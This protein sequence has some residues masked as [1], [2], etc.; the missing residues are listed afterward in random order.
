MRRLVT[1]ASVLG[2]AACL[3]ARAVAQNVIQ[4]YHN[5]FR[6]SGNITTTG[7]LYAHSGNVGRWPGESYTISLTPHATLFSTF[8]LGLDVLLSSQGSD[9]RQNISQFGVNPTLGWATLHLGDFSDDYSEFTI[10]G[11]R[12]R[13]AGLDLKPGIFRFSVQGGQ[14]HRAVFAGQ[15]NI[16]YAQHLYAGMIGLG[17]EGGTHLN[18]MVVKAK[19]DSLSLQPALT[20]T[21]LLD[22]I[23][24]PL[25]PQ[26]QTRPQE[27]LVVG[28]AGQLSLFG[29]RFAL[30]GEGDG[31]VITHDLAADPAK[32]SSVAFGGLVNNFIPL[33]LSTSGDMA[34]KVD[35]TAALGTV[36]LHGGY[37]YVGAGYTSLGLSYVINDREGYNFGGN[38]ALLQSR[39]LVVAQLQHQNDNLLGQKVATTNQDAQTVSLSLRP[40]QTFTA[41]I[42]GLRTLVANDAASDTF[43]VHDQSVAL[44]TNLAY[45]A[46]LLGKQTT[47]SV[48]Y[49]FQRTTDQNVVTPVPRVSVQNVSGSIQI[50][51]TKAISVAPS[52]SIAATQTEGAATQSNAFAGFRG[53]GRFLGGQLRASFDASRSY[54]SSRAITEVHSNLS[55]QLPWASQLT[56]QTRYDHYDASALV[57]A[58]TESFA[59]LSLSRSF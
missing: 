42:T 15:G 54:A 59:T 22:T 37:Q 48:A 23:P 17:R 57:P 44:T 8:S 51:L 35:G 3:P 34:Y 50:G 21:L 9:V 28:A 31:A 14:S 45:Q 58:F 41:T 18:L 16:T 26:A 13:G 7:Q 20:D 1:L 40:A 12:L 36:G 4:A 32:P 19:D 55:F 56:F 52:L 39:I 33:K 10:Q 11:T 27:N 24:L 49:G 29:G 25:R 30:K 46:S 2:I 43:A 6:F 53:D 5:P 38:F 47:L